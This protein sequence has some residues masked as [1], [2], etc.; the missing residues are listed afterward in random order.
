MPNRPELQT[1]YDSLGR[2]ISNKGAMRTVRA[3]KRAEAE[4]RNAQTPEDRRRTY[5]R[6]LGF[7]RQSHAAR[8]IARTVAEANQIAEDVRARSGQDDW[9]SDLDL[10]A[11]GI[12]S[13]S[14]PL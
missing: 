6:A 2:R 9:T 1:R 5:W 8:V 13:G 14:E 7:D 4:A 3:N 12:V 10:V 11:L